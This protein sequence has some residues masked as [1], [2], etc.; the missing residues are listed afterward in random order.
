MYMYFITVMS[1]ANC[2]IDYIYIY[3][4]IVGA[5]GLDIY[6]PHHTFSQSVASLWLSPSF[7][8]TYGIKVFTL[9][10]WPMIV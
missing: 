9:P 7:C 1:I 2:I 6:N 8:K 4:Y 3:I 5:F 10:L